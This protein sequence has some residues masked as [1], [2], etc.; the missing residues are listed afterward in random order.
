M[1]P[2]IYLIG[3]TMSSS[4]NVIRGPQLQFLAV[5]FLKEAPPFLGGTCCW[6]L[7]V[8]WP[9]S[10]ESPGKT[11]NL[12]NGWRKSMSCQKNNI[13]HQ[14]FL[15][16]IRLNFWLAIALG[17]DA[18]EFIGQCLTRDTKNLRS[19]GNTNIFVKGVGGVKSYL[20]FF[21]HFYICYR[22][23]FPGFKKCSFVS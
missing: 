6:K 15:F 14:G 9:F 21:L 11:I 19:L 2:N 4:V 17:M 22:P 18:P 16:L 8:V 12:L 13:R 5:A 10:S 7:A 3:H 1:P 20:S 23:I